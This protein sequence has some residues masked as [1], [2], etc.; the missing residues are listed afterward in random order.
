VRVAL[1]SQYGYN[2]LQPGH[3]DFGNEL[4]A[5]YEPFSA[6]AEMIRKLRTEL[7]LRWFNADRKTLALVSPA[8]ADGRSYLI[9]NLAVAFSQLGENTLLIDAN[10]RTPRLHKIFN[11]DDSSG[12]SSILSGRT[13][14]FDG[15]IPVMELP[16]LHILP[17]GPI[18][19][20]PLELLGQPTLPML[21]AHL[22]DRYGVVLI[23][24][25]SASL[26]ADAQVVAA[27]A[28]G[29]VVLVR[30]NATRA[31]DLK[32]LI[33]AFAAAGTTIV[34]TIMNNK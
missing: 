34:G 15:V 27:R 18:P 17:A 16:G 10:M 26:H 5:A 7:V 30:K 19:P 25:P 21:L 1:S 8:P 22:A 6:Q 24:T 29:A 28:G 4:L 9:A 32:K 2:Y 12:L 3:G 14:Y 11:C 20:N 33:A 31:A 23:D 13:S